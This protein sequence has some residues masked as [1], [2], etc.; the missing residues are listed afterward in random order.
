MNKCDCPYQITFYISCPCHLL[1]WLIW[2]FIAGFLITGRI[3]M[4]QSAFY[5]YKDDKNKPVKI[6]TIRDLE[7]WGSYNRFFTIISSLTDKMKETILLGLKMDYIFMFF[8]YSALYLLGRGVMH[9]LH[10][11]SFWSAVWHYARW[12]PVVAWAMDITEN[13]FTA[14]LLRNISKLK[15][16]IQRIASALKWLF[17]LI[18]LLV[19]LLSVL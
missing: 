16:Q 13:I 17:V 1:D 8:A 15:A 2:L 12:L 14:L 6:S 10:L 3:L 11:T 7:L 18:N 5:F 9:C 19:L 4:T